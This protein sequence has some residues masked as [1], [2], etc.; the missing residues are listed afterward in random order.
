MPQALSALLRPRAQSV[1]DNL[2]KNQVLP[3]ELT[4]TKVEC[5]GPNEY[6]VR[7]Y[8]S[9]LRSVDVSWKKD[10]SFEDVFQAAMVDRVRRLSGPLTRRAG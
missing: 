5:I 8:D 4:A 9:R 7:F 3:F 2:F 10:Q 6:I 1:L